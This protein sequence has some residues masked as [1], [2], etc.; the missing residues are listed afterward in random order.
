M[1]LPSTLSSA[2]FGFS[3]ENLRSQYVDLPPRP[4]CY[5]QAPSHAAGNVLTTACDVVQGYSEFVVTGNLKGWTSW[6]RLHQIKVKAL[7]LGAENDEMDPEDMKKMATMM[8]NATAAICPE[9]SHMAFW[10]SQE[11][12]FK[13]LLPFLHSV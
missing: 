4:D 13:H 11:A 6:D 8:P 7:I 2:D 12:Y 9:G 5:P 3:A 1:M 10:D